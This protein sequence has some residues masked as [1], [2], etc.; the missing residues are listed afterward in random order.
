MKQ[1][2]LPLWMQDVFISLAECDPRLSRMKPGTREYKKRLNKIVQEL[3][4]DAYQ[5]A[6]TPSGQL[7]KNPYTPAISKAFYAQFPRVSGEDN[8]FRQAAREGKISGAEVRSQQERFRSAVSYLT[9]MV[10]RMKLGLTSK[11]F[12]IGKGSTEEAKKKVYLNIFKRY[13][14]ATTIISA[15]RP[16]FELT[17]NEIDRFFEK[18]EINENRPLDQLASNAVRLRFVDALKSGLKKEVFTKEDLKDFLGI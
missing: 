7:G 4:D 16:V 8:I 14:V 5:H 10:L 3:A 6:L 12:A 15:L 17:P 13:F 18:N 1:V 2:Q 11:D 9:N